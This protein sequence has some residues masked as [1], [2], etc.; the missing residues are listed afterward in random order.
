MIKE[1]G[2]LS[3]EKYS[4]NKD[5]IKEIFKKNS[6]KFN[7]HEYHT[8][9]KFVWSDDN[10][11]VEAKYTSDS[12]KIVIIADKKYA[13]IADIK[14][15][16]KSLDGKWKI[17]PKEKLEANK[18]LMNAEEIK[19]FDKKSMSIIINEQRNSMRKGFK[20]C[21]ILKPM[22]KDY[23]EFRKSKFNVDSKY[24]ID[25]LYDEVI[26]KTKHQIDDAFY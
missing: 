25:S 3:R 1:M 6:L 26:E 5:A 7:Q 9:E 23:L 8:N 14:K 19:I 10:I 20:I 22:I 12:V 21:P 15:I 13:F 24:T 11:T 4:Q 17:V 18:D 2:V 16:V